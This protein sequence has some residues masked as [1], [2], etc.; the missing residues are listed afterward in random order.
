VEPEPATDPS[1]ER[2]K[3]REL[4]PELDGKPYV[5]RSKSTSKYNCVAFALGDFAHNWM[6]TLGPSGKQL[7]GYRWPDDL[8]RDDALPTVKEIFRRRGFSECDSNDPGEGVERVA[9]YADRLG[10]THVAYQRPGGPWASKMGDAADIE[11]DE[12]EW[13]ECPMV[14]RFV[15]VMCRQAGKPDRDPEPV[16]EVVL[17]LPANLSEIS[18]GG[19]RRTKP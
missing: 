8:P 13:V 15:E 5:L 19:V 14:G 9:F 4:C 17:Q 12:P 7:G 16:L 18:H 1:R 10:C 3:L 6:P 2:R 11:H